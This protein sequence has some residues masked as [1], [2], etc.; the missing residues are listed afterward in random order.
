[1]LGTWSRSYAAGVL[2]CCSRIIAMMSSRCTGALV[3]VQ[4]RCVA[5]SR[6]FQ[7]RSYRH[8]Q[9]IFVQ[10][11]QVNLTRLQASMLAALVS[12]D[13]PRQ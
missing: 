6:L 9:A 10:S 5:R 13:A 4:H 11:P 12:A 7:V 8:A 1:M 3:P 2:A